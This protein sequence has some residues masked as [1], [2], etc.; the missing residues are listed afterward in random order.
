MYDCSR[1]STKWWKKV[2]Y[3]LLMSA[4]VNS[5]ILYNEVN[6][7]KTRLLQFLVPLPEQ[8]MAMG[9]A[10]SAVKHRRNSGRPSKIGKTMIN[11][12]DHLPVEGTTRRCTRCSMKKKETRTKQTCQMCF[13]PLCKDCFTFYHTS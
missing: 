5:W 8:I 3:K 12:E 9:K 6:E 11:V 7:K 10:N 4:V 1:K 13:L 2:F